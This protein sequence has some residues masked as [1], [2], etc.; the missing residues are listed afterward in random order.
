MF[1]IDED[2][3]LQLEAREPL[4]SM[5]TLSPFVWRVGRT[6]QIVL[7]AVNRDDDPAKKVARVY[8]GRSDDG[9]RFCMD[10]E[11]DIAPGPG[12]DDRD[13]CEDPSVA[14][15]G[16]R[17]LVYYTGW[18]QSKKEGKLLVASG[19]NVCRLQKDGVALDSTPTHANPKEA[20]IA[21][22]EDGS[23]VLFFEYARD[24]RSRMGLARSPR[25]DGPWQMQ[26]DPMIARDAGWDSWH[27]SPGPV[28]PFAD[29]VV[30]FYNGADD[31]AAWRIGWTLFEKDF[32][33]VVDRGE[34]PLIVPP[35]PA[36]DETDIAFVASAVAAADATWLYYSVADRTMKRA[37]VR[38]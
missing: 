1:T 7:R 37:T 16:D 11:P 29:R 35:R 24:N 19:S 38:S 4:R 36:G 6:L 10:R 14:V 17:I 9:L 26:H 12:A 21:R 18:N 28:M 13:G 34:R 31:K 5:Y 25:V 33:T 2:V 8:H 3:E 22:C 32:S 23:W 27:L 15:D 20:T 30:M